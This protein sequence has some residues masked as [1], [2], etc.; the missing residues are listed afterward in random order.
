MALASWS[1]LLFWPLTSREPPESSAGGALNL[2]FGFATAASPCGCCLVFG[3]ALPGKTSSCTGLGSCALAVSELLSSA[4]SCAG[5][6]RRSAS[7]ARLA[8]CGGAGITR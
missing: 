4:T 8:A 7:A 2:L 6:G 3:R 1:E 5:G